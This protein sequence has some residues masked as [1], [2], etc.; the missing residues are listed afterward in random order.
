M[1]TP[2]VW[3]R[4]YYVLALVLVCS[5]LAVDRSKFRTCQ[6]T[7]FCRR[8]RDFQAPTFRLLP[9]SVT[10]H[11]L[12]ASELHAEQQRRLQEEQQAAQ[13][14]EQA[15]VWKSLQRR[16]LGDSSAGAGGTNK[17]HDPYVR[18]PPPTLSG[19]LAQAGTNHELQWTVSVL[20]DGIA[21]MR[22]TEVYGQSGTAF[23]QARVTY[24]ELVLLRGGM[25]SADH[26]VWLKP[27]DE[28]ARHVLFK[29]VG[30]DDNL[31]NYMGLEYGDLPGKPGT[32]L[33]IQLDPFVVKLFRQADVDSGAAKPIIELGAQHMM[34]FE[35]RKFKDDA[36]VKVKENVAADAGQ[37]DETVQHEKKI[38]GYWEDGLAIYEDGSREEKKDTS[39]EEPAK[40][41]GDHEHRKLSE[42]DEEGLWEEKFGSHTDSKPYG[43]MSVG[44]DISFPQSH[45]I[46]GIPEHASSA[47]LK[48]TRGQDAHYKEPY[49]LY[50][51]DVFE[52]EL[53]ETMALYGNIP[54]LVSQ[55][56]ETGTSGVFY[57]NPTETFVDIMHDDSSTTSHW[58]SESGVLDLF[59]LP[60]SNPESLYRQYAQLT[61]TSALPP[62]FS[63]GY[64]Q[65]RWNYKD[66]KD[67]A[68]VHGKFEELDYPYDV[69]W[70][71]IEHTDGKRY[72]TWDKATFPDPKPM[73]EKLA[74]Q[75]RR[76]VT[77]VDPHIKRDD[78]YYIHKEA[79]QKGL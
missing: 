5:A 77:I 41:E 15:G 61:G 22:V 64:H 45:H 6:Q 69:L 67:V 14:Q 7:S 57:F 52:Y 48:S 31:G 46:Y 74:S 3:H 59:L 73:Q 16:L 19:R 72:F 60:G 76:M 68:Q 35:V 34:H 78:N 66:E 37:G 39:Q 13:Q 10:W 43:P 21:R 49:R 29:L 51:L 65:C 23:E 32:V 54:L 1:K 9:D 18:G 40:E 8:H 36:E 30:S 24:D 42:D 50:N 12:E 47:T 71:D 55:S 17:D 28:E 75:G 26:A 63:L 33:L 56:I 4:Y 58:I 2:R 27:Q 38:V 44:I 70:L 53:D 62:M 25:Q 11:G 20:K 79:T